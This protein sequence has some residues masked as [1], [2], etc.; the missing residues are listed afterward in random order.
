MPLSKRIQDAIDRHFEEQRNNNNFAALTRDQ[1]SCLSENELRWT[2]NHLKR[3]TKMLDTILKGRH[4]GPAS[5]K[6]CLGKRV[7]FCPMC[8]SSENNVY[9]SYGTCKAHIRKYHLEL[10]PFSCNRCSYENF[11]PDC[12]KKHRANCK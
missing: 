1:V 8:V 10:P 5:F 6:N 7:Y 3:I 4:I 12:I 2:V 11:N 9:K